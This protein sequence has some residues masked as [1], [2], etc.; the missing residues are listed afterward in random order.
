MTE[1]LGYVFG[2]ASLVDYVEPLALPTGT[3]QPVYGRVTG[4][5]RCWNAGF[6]NLSPTRDHKHYV[7]AAT[8]ARPDICVVS[9]N[10]ERAPRGDANG[11]AIPVNRERLG[12]IDER[13]QEMVR[14]DVTAA[15]S[16]DLSATVW[17]YFADAAAHRRFQTAQAEGRAFVGKRYLERVAQGFAAIGPETLSEYQATT[18]K[19]EVPFRDLRLTKHS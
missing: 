1:L 15:F 14:Q 19:P 13:E 4:Y 6:E 10:L 3:V 7:D 2:Y 12:E 17:T 16:P 11:L 18:P 8:G 5:A 9:L